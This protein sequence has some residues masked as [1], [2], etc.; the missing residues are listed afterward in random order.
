MTED[1]QSQISEATQR[2]SSGASPK[3]LLEEYVTR[4]DLQQAFYIVTQAQILFK[5]NR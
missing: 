5:N 3:K 4:F 2:L 1:L